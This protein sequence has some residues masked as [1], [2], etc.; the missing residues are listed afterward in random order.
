MLVFIVARVWY[1]FTFAISEHDP[2]FLVVG[3]LPRAESAGRTCEWG[4]GCGAGGTGEVTGECW[5]FKFVAGLIFVSGWGLA[6]GE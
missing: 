1:L 6:D 5:E 4:T 3:V 2:A